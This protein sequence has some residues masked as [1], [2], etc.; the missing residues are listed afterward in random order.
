MIRSIKSKI[1]LIIIV[2]IALTIGNSLVA[3]NYFNKLRMS[4]ELIMDANYDSVVAAQNMNNELEREDNLQISFI[5]GDDFE[6]SPEYELRHDSF[7]MWL[8]KAKN[9]ITE[10]GEQDSVNSIEKSYI[11][12][13]DKGGILIGIKINQ[14]DNQAS[15]YY[16]NT[17][18]PLFKEVKSN[19]NNL[20]DINQ[21]S[22]TDMKEKSKELADR[23]IYYTLGIDV[24]VLIIGISIISYLLRKIIHPIEDLVIGINE[25]SEGNY[26]YTIPLE[27]GKEINY[28]LN[29]FNNMVH[30]LKEYDKLNV[31]KI[32]RQKQRTEAIIESIMSPI[33]VT[34][35]ENKII[36]L[37]KS[38]ERVFDIKEKRLL[39]D[40]F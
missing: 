5:F 33:I 15:K 22:M 14:G 7:I 23:A 39:I 38:A 17:V 24:L 11:E 16:Y 13:L 36:M 20:L 4:I 32:L 9:N 10:V 6:I 18:L 29:C 37:N 21:K 25:V 19:C 35:D 34:D 2:F 3:V 8:D 40:N 12:Y 31:K 26:E 28:I 1:F 30:K 27:R